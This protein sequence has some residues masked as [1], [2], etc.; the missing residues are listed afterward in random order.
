MAYRD[1]ILSKAVEYVREKKLSSANSRAIVMVDCPFCHF[2]K[3]AQIIPSLA[4]IKCVH[5]GQ[6][7]TLID[8][9]RSVEH[10]ENE[11]EEQILN[12]VRDL[13]KIDVQ[14]TKDAEDLEKI[15]QVYDTR[16][17]ALVPCAKA[18][19]VGVSGNKVTTGKEVIQAEWQ[20]KENRKVSEWFHWLN[21]GLNVGVR[22]GQVSNLTI[23]DFD[24]L[25]KEEK[26]ELVKETT[27]E[28]RKAEI[29]AK[30]VIPASIKT[31]LGDTLMSESHGGFHC[32]YIY[33]PELR[34]TGINFEGIHIDIENDGGQVIIYPSQR[35]GV[36]EE[37]KDGEEIKKRI[38]GHAGR[39]FINELPMIPIPPE[40][41]VFLKDKTDKSPKTTTEDS[42]IIIEQ[43]LTVP[44]DFKVKDLQN[45]RNNT[46][47]TLGG[48]FRKEMNIKQTKFVLSV[49]NK[50]L[51][52]QPLPSQEIDHITE[53]LDNYIGH[54][55]KSLANEIVEYLKETDTAAKTEI[56]SA[57]FGGRTNSENKKRLD[58][59]LMI[60]IRE[61]KIV[62]KNAR[63]YKILKNMEW[64]TDFLSMGRPLDFKVPYLDNYAYFNYG[65][66]VLIGAVQKFGKTTIGI[67]II[68]RLVDQGVK[69]YYIYSESG[70]RFSKTTC[71]LGM[72]ENDFIFTRC[73]NPEEIILPKN[74]VVIYDW[75][76]PRDFA[77]T[78]A[79][80]ETIVD[81]L[82]KS[83]SFM[84]GFVQ[85]REGS[86]KNK[87]QND[88]F[89][90]DLVRQ[91]V[92]MSAKYLYED[93]D[94]FNTYFELGDIRD[95]KA[96]GKTYKISCNYDKIT[97]E[98]KTISEI[99]AEERAKNKPIEITPPISE[100]S[101]PSEVET[102]D[103]GD[104]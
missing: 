92:A 22:T 57:C 37:F 45:N 40:L 86:E 58:R 2:T 23:I 1:I 97:R 85:L 13:L 78:D 93:N 51:L 94:G 64:K 60:L 6:M 26:A 62:K 95:S 70:G 39:K 79:M 67:N 77:K 100:Q 10:K 83:Q 102:M 84:I 55:E 89:A 53:G 75:I 80:F 71:K 101:I 72:K 52:E 16:H 96:G 76:R 74:S 103:P 20:K 66:L 30:K 81:K 17:W 32:F 25:S 7:F 99:E 35:I 46:L 9:I 44:E 59:T 15:L 61:E 50:H 27:S 68:K 19:N 5:C 14:T 91:H 98:V 11:S 31:L 49:L 43:A 47:L 3:S 88:W 38:V 104:K 48:I 28:P 87:N 56:E 63:D 90:K 54:D 34:K 33:T 69:P 65:D 24:L 41:L 12:Y 73:S 82:D 42:G 18:A 8:L 29:M 36:E 21:T 4:H